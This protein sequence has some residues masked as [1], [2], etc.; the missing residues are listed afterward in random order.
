MA[1]RKTGSDKQ[2]ALF[3]DDPAPDAAPTSTAAAAAD[4]TAGPAATCHRHW[5]DPRCGI[6]A[7]AADWLLAEARTAPGDGRG[8]GNTPSDDRIVDLSPFTVVVPGRAAGHR[9]IEILIDKTALPGPAKGGRSSQSGRLVPPQIVT[10]GTLPEELYEPAKPLADT[11]TETLCWVVALT[12]ANRRDRQLIA[13]LPEEPT[14]GDS[15]DA[16]RSEPASRSTDDTFAAGSLDAARMMVSMHRELAAIGLS[17][18]DLSDA[19]DGAL[20]GFGDHARWQALARLEKVYLAEIDGLGFWDRQTARRVAVE[21]GEVAFT[22]RIVLLATVDVDPLQRKMLAGV[23]GRIDA[24]VPL[25]GDIGPDPEACFDDF[26]C[27]VPAAWQD[28][29]LPLPLDRIAVVDDGDSQAVAVVEW[30]RGLADARSADEITVAVPDPAVVPAIE[31]RLATVGLA[32]RYA[33][34]RTVE[35]SSPWQFVRAIFAWMRRREF[36]PLADLLRC[37]DCIALLKRRAGE[38]IPAAIADGVALRHLPW[39]VDRDHL[40]AAASHPKER[41]ENEAFVTILDCLD[42]WLAPLAAAATAVDAAQRS[43]RWQPA[44]AR[45]PRPRRAAAKAGSTAGTSLAAAWVRGL[46]DACTAAVEGIDIDR[47]DASTRVF[48]HSLAALGE[49]LADLETLPDRLVAAAGSAGMERLLLSGWGRSQLP[50]PQDP[51]AIELVGWLEVALDDSPALAITSCVE[52][53]LPGSAGRDPLLPEPLR[54]ALGLDSATRTAARDAWMLAVAA[55]RDEFLVVVPRRAADGSPA[56]PSRLLFRRSPDEVVDAAKR[57]FATPRAEAMAGPPTVVPAR[58]AVPAPSVVMAKSPADFPPMKVT[59]FRDYLAC[60]YR[61]WLKHRLGLSTSSDEALELG[62]GDFGTLIHECLDRFGKNEAIASSTDP[63]EIG[64]WLS[65]ALDRFIDERYGPG[66]APAVFVQA[67]L[68]RRRLRE[69]ARVQA[70]RTGE[71]WVIHATEQVVRSSAFVVDGIPVRLSGKIDR[72]DHHPEEDRWEVLDYKTSAR[73]KTPDRTHRDSHGWIDLQLPLYR[74]LL[75]E[76]AGMPELDLAKPDRVGVGYFNVPARVE[77]IRIET[78]SW[79]VPEY[80]SA[81]DAAREV[82]RAVR[83]ER[84][85]PP[86]DDA[87]GSFPEFDAICQTHTIRDEEDEGESA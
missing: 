51:T 43:T 36:A 1:R 47:D 3:A 26:G 68:A 59:E 82:V 84:F 72:I 83:E 66:A 13:P 16:D 57:L 41:A 71:G 52:G 14:D 40:A 38:A 45:P 19:A 17:F 4:P 29:P 24:L 77:E 80:D 12:A 79:T 15:D 64:D 86:N 42:A 18:A 37:P 11:A 85:W 58:L 34:G 21:R 39:E 53:C 60:P 56:V 87:A 28:R 78:A 32:G 67:E 49:A 30:I 35:R 22:G 63:H 74:H 61:Y 31:Q 65:A 5:L 7:S 20:P 54:Q 62:P 46:R 75:V 48:S 23:R 2:Q 55:A 6:L 25:P 81:D 33:A 73:G 70:D 76:V 9:L 69:F 8:Q 10:L 27:L 44:P 50:P